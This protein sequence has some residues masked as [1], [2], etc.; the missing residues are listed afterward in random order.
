MFMHFNR[1]RRMLVAA[2]YGTPFLARFNMSYRSFVVA[3]SHSVLAISS[4]NF[5]KNKAATTQPVSWG[6]GVCVPHRRQYLCCRRPLRS[7]SILPLPAVSSDE[8]DWNMAAD[9]EPSPTPRLLPPL[10]VAIAESCQLAHLL[11]IA[12]IGYSQLSCVDSST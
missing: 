3:G 5:A 11:L 6:D 2:W 10:Y 12:T 8:L 1:R 4:D 9:G 7:R